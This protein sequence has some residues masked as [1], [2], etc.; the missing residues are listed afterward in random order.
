YAENTIPIDAV[1]IVD[2]WGNG[3]TELDGISF[4]DKSYIKLREVILS[5]SV[6]QKLL[7]E[8]PIGKIQLSVIG[9]NLLLWTPEDQHYI[10]PELTT[11]GNDLEADFG[12]Y[13]AQPTVRSVT[14]SLRFSL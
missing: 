11:F 12:E 4:I 1:H 3:G 7:K 9:R 6:P 10:D 8:L 5:Y 2:Y 13:G 14:F